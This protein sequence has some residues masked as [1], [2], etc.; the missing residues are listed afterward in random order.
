MLSPRALRTAVSLAI[1]TALSVG[2]PGDVRANEPKPADRF[3]KQMGNLEAAAERLSREFAN[4][5][6][7]V[8]RFPFHKRLID[9]QVF[10]ELGN[11]ESA[12]IVLLDVLDNPSFRGNLETENAQLLLAKSLLRIGN[13]KP[14]RDLLTEVTRGRDMRLAEQARFYLIEV[15]LSDGSE[16]VLRDIVAQM[17]GSATSDR[18]RYALA[19]AHLRLGD[20]DKAILWLKV[21]G[22]QSELFP[23]AQYYLA[24]AHTANKQYQQALDI[25]TTLARSSGDTDEDAERRDLAWLAVGRLQ[26]ELGALGTSL[27]SYQNIGR[28]S[29]HY[30]V[31]LYEMAWAYIKQ[32]QYDK[33]LLTVDILLLTVQ[34]EQI[35]VDAHVLRGRLSVLM[36]EYEEAMDSYTAILNRF[37]PIRNELTRFTRDP[38]DIQRYF[39]WLLERQ[40]GEARLH[41]P[42][43]QRTSKW[44]ESTE[45]IARV[46]TVF[47][48][49]SGETRDIDQASDI[50]KELEKLLSSNN[51]VEL[52]PNLRD[53]WTRA[54]VLQNRLLLLS[55]AILDAEAASLA[56]K[57]DASDASEMAE[58]VAWRRNLEERANALPTTFEAYGARK[59][60]VNER[61]LDLERKHFIVEQSLADVKRQLLALE[62]YLNDKQFADGGD[63]LTDAHERSVRDDL[64][65]E[66]SSLQ[67]LFDE[68]TDLKKVIDVEA[69]RVG[70]GD[71]ANQ[72]EANLKET[73]IAAHKREGEFYERLGVQVGGGTAR[74]LREL[75]DLRQRTRLAIARVD[76][77][78]AAIDDEVGVKTVELRGQVA[79][80]L[81]AL[82][83]YATEVSL[84]DSEGRA[85]ART[86]GEELFRRAQSRMDNVVLE[87]DVGILDVVWERK[88]QSTRELQSVN[89]QRSDR[90]RQLQADL[91]ALR[92][93]A[94]D[95]APD[96]VGGT[97]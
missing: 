58:L 54:L 1:M 78:I 40:S 7:I 52:F 45:D 37:A 11:Y 84:Y 29:P 5:L 4:P 67:G 69:R 87:A 80:E 18:T 73:L 15:A 42:L 66:K 14:A 97:P 71:A 50:G 44:I 77:V 51:R 62:R 70:I 28:H 79:R 46:A 24:V 17:G 88:Q 61:F 32:E 33:A 76:T 74:D 47:D 30:E 83:A 96:G 41:A 2:Q 9:A 53:G 91:K 13:V 57:V 6:A 3:R 60:R 55:S 94:A 34:D 59:A 65:E 93:G 19:K 90:L 12:A 48:R 92:H 75:S 22:A 43:S 81:H 95:G 38:D 82:K 31:A 25:F 64:Q 27:T 21:I 10:Y 35:N 56:G 36:S 86:M 23:K 68:L 85:L 16:Q 63:K 20:P 8:Q 49:I 39:Q 72:G 26:A 89:G